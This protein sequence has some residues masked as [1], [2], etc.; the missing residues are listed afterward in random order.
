MAIP[1]SGKRQIIHRYFFALKQF[2]L[3]E[4]TA[5]IVNKSK[6]Q[7]RSN[8]HKPHCLSHK[9]AEITYELVLSSDAIKWLL[10]P[11]Y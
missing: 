4:Q 11:I 3:Q 8:L 10:E 2:H 1:L 6:L 9:E 5:Y 7:F